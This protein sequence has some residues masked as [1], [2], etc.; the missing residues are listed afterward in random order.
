[1]PKPELTHAQ[2]E[3]LM[4]PNVPKP[5]HGLN[6]R[7]ILGREWWDAT[8]FEAQRRTGYHCAA[9]GVHKRDAKAHAWL[10]GHEYW[11][12]DYAS[13]RCEVV[14]IEPLC[15]Y[16]HNF[17]HSGRLA[18]CDKDPREVFA[19]VN[20]GFAILAANSLRCFPGTLRLA[21]ILGCDTHGVKAYKLPKAATVAEWSDFR[22]VLEGREYPSLFAS[23]DEWC[24]H[25]GG[26][27]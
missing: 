25:Y 9:C 16:C 15:H 11:N 4:Q 6:P 1:M 24:E 26:K 20:H 13:G 22:L 8:R 10:E 7:T 21:E 5:L 19:I 2:P 23:F 18:V 14:R 3:I 12:L 27:Q 17:I